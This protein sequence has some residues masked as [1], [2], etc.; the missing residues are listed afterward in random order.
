MP[1]G[2]DARTEELVRDLERL[3]PLDPRDG[4]SKFRGGAA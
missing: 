1:D 4:L 2:L 3:M